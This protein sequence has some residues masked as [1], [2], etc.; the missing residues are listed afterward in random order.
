MK[1]ISPLLMAFNCLHFAVF[2]KQQHVFLTQTLQQHTA[3]RKGNLVKTQTALP[4]LMESPLNFLFKKLLFNYRCPNFPT[5]TLPCPAQSIPTLLCITM[6]PLY[7]LLDQTLPLLSPVIL[8]PPPLQSLSVCS[9]F[10]CLWFYLGH[11]FV[12]FIRF[13]IQMRSYGICLLPP[14]LFHLA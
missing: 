9:S 2:L 13:H 3:T 7:I 14:G 12:L 8:L 4:C 11:L 10:L 5:I 6:G 1:T